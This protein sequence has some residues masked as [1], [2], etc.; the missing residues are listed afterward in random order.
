MRDEIDFYATPGP[1]TRLV[2]LDEALAGMPTDPAGIAAVVQAAD[3]ADL[4]PGLFLPAGEAWLRCQ[5]GLEDGDT[6]ID[7]VA[8][9]TVSDDHEAIRQR[10]ET[11]EGL[12]VPPRVLAFYTPNGPAEVDVAELA[13]PNSRSFPRSF[14]TPA[15]VGS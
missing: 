10:Y 12:R 15:T 6:Y 2:G 9:L 13:C 7:A 1:M 11:D 14:L 5:A 8:A 4:P 3:P